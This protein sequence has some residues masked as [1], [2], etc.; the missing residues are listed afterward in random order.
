[1]SKHTNTKCG[2]IRELLLERLREHEATPDGLPTTGR[3]LFYEFEQRGEATKECK[4]KNGKDSKSRRNFGWPPGQSDI[5][6][7]LTA[8]RDEGVIEWDWIADPE[9][10]LSEWS[11][12]KNVN[13]CVDDA[14]K[15]FSLNPWEPHEPPLILTESKSLALVLETVA[16]RYLCPI[17]GLRGHS[18]GHLRTKI[19]PL[20][21]N[22]RKV[23]YLGDHDDCGHVIEQRT[24]EI[25]QHE[26]GR[27]LNWT[28]IGLTEAQIRARGITPIMKTDKRYDDKT[29]RKCWECEALG[30]SAIF[31]L[32]RS[33]L[34]T[35]LFRIG[36]GQTLSRVHDRENR[37]RR[38]AQRKLRAKQ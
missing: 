23:L 21:W 36:K 9:R 17:S 6:D 14:L 20:L 11:Y 8:M 30:Q 28:R 18:N 12:F 1:M 19:A 7:E 31:D 32:V 3:I 2:R 25:L 15:Y 5:T 22:G 29:P 33:A 24:R 16:S 4:D 13:E 38:A 34:R 26:T 27:E 10:S 35:L 37:E